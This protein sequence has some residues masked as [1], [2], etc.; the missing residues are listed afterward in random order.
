MPSHIIHGF[1]FYAMLLLLMP[2]AGLG[3]R[4]SAATGLESVWEIVE[5][6]DTVIQRYR[7][8]TIS[9]EYFGDSVINSMADIAAM[10]IGFSIALRLPVWLTITLAI[11]IESTT[12]WLIRDG[13]VLNVLMLLWPVETIRQWQ[14]A[15]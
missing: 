10:M 7:E 8:A 4:L 12:T 15:I 9:L 13:L 14:S 6:T 3:W 5:N 11:V 1:V 2:R